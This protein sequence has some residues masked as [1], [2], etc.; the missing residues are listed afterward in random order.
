MNVNANAGVA[1]PSFQ[2]RLK[3]NKVTEKVVNKMNEDQLT[4]FKQALTNL[5][6]V[7]P[8]D[9]VEISKKTQGSSRGF[10]PYEVN[11]YYVKNTKDNK[12]ETKFKSTVGNLEPEDL[13][14]VVKKLANPKT[15][16]SKTVLPENNATV[17]ANGKEQAKKEVLD[18]MA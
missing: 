17:Q 9:V 10:G 4:V 8:N 12:S 7:A 11:D 3:N 13:I 1:T 18:M 16:I 6:K 2:A 5:S 14:S 15:K